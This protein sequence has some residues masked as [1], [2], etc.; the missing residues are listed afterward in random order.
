MESSSSPAL[1]P[2]NALQFIFPDSEVCVCVCVC[3][4]MYV[5][6]ALACM[7]KLSTISGVIPT[8][9]STLIL[10]QGFFLDRIRLGWLARSSRGLTPSGHL[11]DYKCVPPTTPSFPHGFLDLYSGLHAYVKSTLPTEQSLQLLIH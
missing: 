5:S 7:R 11:W 10:R 2:T 3:V 9:L 6:V 8:E 4:C 1:H